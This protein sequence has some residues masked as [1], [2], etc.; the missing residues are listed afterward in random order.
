VLEISR[1]YTTFADGV[2][3]SS[4]PRL[5]L[6]DILKSL[7]TLLISVN[8]ERLVRG[9]ICGEFKT[10]LSVTGYFSSWWFYPPSETSFDLLRNLHGSRF[11]SVVLED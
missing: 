3:A 11:S 9:L 4:L 10:L 6:R 2:H 8:G 1:S 5:T 7:E